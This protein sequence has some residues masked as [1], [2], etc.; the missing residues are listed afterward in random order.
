MTA[1]PPAST[2]AP[3]IHGLIR[4]LRLP[5]TP[6]SAVTMATTDTPRSAGPVRSARSPQETFPTAQRMRAERA[7]LDH[8]AGVLS[9][10]KSTIAR[11]LSKADQELTQTQRASQE[12]SAQ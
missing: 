3:M 10:G 1:A 4:A 12:W 8:I 9:V 6:R 2:T 7:S 5:M 11:A